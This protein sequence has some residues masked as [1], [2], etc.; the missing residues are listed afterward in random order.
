MGM[1]VTSIVCGVHCLVRMRLRY[2]YLIVGC[3]ECV[4]Y[5]CDSHPQASAQHT[6]F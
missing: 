1:R 6:S 2:V 5:E 3:V 4:I